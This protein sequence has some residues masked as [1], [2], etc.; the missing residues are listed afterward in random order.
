VDHAIAIL[1]SDP[2]ERHSGAQVTCRQRFDTL[3]R[4]RARATGACRP[5]PNPI[6]LSGSVSLGF[7]LLGRSL[8]ALDQI[9]RSKRHAPIW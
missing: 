7:D 5:N 9:G 4:H 3:V 2:D 6:R 1:R 8:Q